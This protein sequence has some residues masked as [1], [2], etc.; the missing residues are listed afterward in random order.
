MRGAIDWALDH[1]LELAFRLTIAMEQF[2]VMNDPFE[3]VRRLSVLV[4]CGAEIAPELRARALRCLGEATWVSGDLER[5][6]E[7]MER[8]RAEFERLGDPSGVAVLLHRLSVGAVAANDFARARQLLDECQAI[9]RDRPDA[10]LEADV[11]HKAGLGRARRGQP[12]ARARAVRRGGEAVWRGRFRWMQANGPLTSP[13]FSHELGPRQTSPRNAGLEALRLS[14]GGLDRQFI[15]LRCPCSPGSAIAD[16]RTGTRGRLW[17]AIEAE[18]AR[19]RGRGSLGSGSEPS[20][21]RPSSGR[22]P[23]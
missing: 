2:W 13:S 4:D 17:G 18:E 8:C 21:R 1:D 6:D 19:G 16:G 20:T 5:G 22:G 12:R 3:G 15:V 11:A 10:R 9:C 14:C 7:L 23:V